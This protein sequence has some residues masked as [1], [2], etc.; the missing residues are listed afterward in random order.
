LRLLI[1]IDPMAP[2]TSLPVHYNHLIQGCL[3]HCLGDDTQ[4]YHDLG[5]RYRKRAFKLF[6]FSRI[7]GRSTYDSYTG[8]LR[9]DGEMALVVTSP[10]KRFCSSLSTGLLRLG[11]IHVRSECLNIDSILA[12]EDVV[13]SSQVTV[14]LL[15]PV[16]VYSTMTRY[17]G[18]KYT[19]YFAPGEPDFE[20]LVSENLKRKYE[21]FT[22]IN[23][24]TLDSVKVTPLGEPRL[25]VLKYKDTVIKGY[26]CRLRLV[27][28]IPLLQMA[29]D[30]GLGAKNSQGFG[31]IE[32]DDRRTNK[33]YVERGERNPNRKPDSLGKAFS[34]HRQSG[35]PR[36]NPSDY[37]RGCSGSGGILQER[38]SC[39]TRLHE[40]VFHGQGGRSS[41]EVMG[42]QS[43]G[44]QYRRRRFSSK[45][46][47]G[48]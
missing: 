47:K 43:D 16:V 21:A 29:V 31:C 34:E 2:H 20:R 24:T 30:A 9:F 1:K 23:G 44:S 37:R 18:R 12:S 26:T 42:R 13:E 6:S 48:Y 25:A 4:F 33:D 14:R 45:A 19:C 15:S 22:G 7:L 11:A 36:H 28:P 46:P 38:S 10:D 5:Y 35:G 40:W 17:D 8:T 32:I 27:G 3:Y 39:R 41:A